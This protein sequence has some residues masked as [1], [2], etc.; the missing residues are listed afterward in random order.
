MGM[1]LVLCIVYIYFMAFFANILAWI[2]IALTQIA[3][4]VLCAGSFYMWMGMADNNPAKN[5]ALIVGII[6][7]ILALLFAVSLWCGWNSLKLAIEIVNTSADFLAATKRL[8]AVP[9]LYYFFLFLFFLFWVGCVICVESMGDIVPN[10][11]D[12]IQYIPLDKDVNWGDKKLGHQ[13]NIML[14]FLTFGLIWFTFFLTASNNYVVMV[15]AS[16]YYFNNDIGKEGSGEVMTGMR[17]AWVQNF[18]S[19]AFGSLIIAIIWTIKVLVYYVCKK[20]EAASGNN[21]FVKCLTCIAMC[22]IG[23]IEKIIDYINKAAYAFM[24]ISGNS[25]CS[26]AYNGLLLQMKHGG[27]FAFGNYLASMFILL[28]KIGLTVLNVFLTWMFMT[29]ISGSAARVSSPYAPLFIVAVCT[30][31]IVSVFL[32]LF[33]ES[34]LALMT[35]FTADLDLNGGTPAWGPETLQN[36]V[37]GM[38]NDG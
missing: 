30:F 25:F 5:T 11:G 19:L 38:F 8:L 17:W 33:D 34:V 29:R 15:T 28:G 20:A 36:T 12:R 37:L 10:P 26:S 21:G 16:T 2:I 3:F 9:L 32:G 14:A 23:C 6:T 27:K 24:A 7:G 18:G 35:S 31:L 13:V 4:I 1:A 22:L